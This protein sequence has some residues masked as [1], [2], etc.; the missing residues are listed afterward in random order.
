[1]RIYSSSSSFSHTASFQL[2]PHLS[3]PSDVYI[4]S[5]AYYDTHKLFLTGLSNGLLLFWN[6]MTGEIQ[7]A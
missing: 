4:S 6:G 1:M 5:V 7:G 3:L 2:P